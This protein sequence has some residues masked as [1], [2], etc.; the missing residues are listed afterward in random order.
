[1]NDTG[2]DILT[3]KIEHN[4][5]ITQT[6]KNLLKNRERKT[7]YTFTDNQVTFINQQ[8]FPQS[9]NVSMYTCTVVQQTQNNRIDC[10]GQVLGAREG[11]YIKQDRFSFITVN[12]CHQEKVELSSKAE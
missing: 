4:G 8:I 3:E 2:T 12:K 10:N 9:L 11:Q 1:M 6:T 7:S 5:D